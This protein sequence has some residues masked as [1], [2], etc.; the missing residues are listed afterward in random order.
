LEG[1]P[2]QPVDNAV[3]LSVTIPLPLFN[4]NQGDIAAAIA[5]ERQATQSVEALR[6]AIG[7]EV[8]AIYQ[9]LGRLATTLTAQQ[10]RMLPLSERNSVLA[11][12]AYAQ[13]QIS[14]IEVVQVER[15]R[16]ELRANYLNI[17][18]RYLQSRARL[19][20]AIDAWFEL[21]TRVS[22]YPANTEIMEK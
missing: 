10:Q 3:L 9:E 21:A 8:A 11:R 12:D 5:A 19:D 7:I 2:R 16:N 1:A 14:I 22:D 6:L 15:L 17:Y 13:G 18:G 20:T 4:R